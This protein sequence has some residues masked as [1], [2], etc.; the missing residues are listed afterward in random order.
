MTCGQRVRDSCG[1]HR[2]ADNVF[3]GD[4]KAERVG[5]SDGT[6]EVWR[7]ESARG[8]CHFDIHFVSGVAV[9]EGDGWC[10][11]C[12]NEAQRFAQAHG[13]RMLRLLSADTLE[14]MR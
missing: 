4:F 8:C 9:I 11:A 12:I 14:R 1:A 5:L 10:L 6:E 2:S 7:L 3:V 13:Y